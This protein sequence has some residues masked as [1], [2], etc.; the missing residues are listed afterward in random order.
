MR[1]QTIRT[2]KLFG[3]FNHVI[4]LNA[5]DRITII[6]GPNG[7][8]KTA[9]LRLISDIFESRNT[10]V[11]EL[12]FE[13]VELDFDDDSTLVVRKT[14]SGDE[15]HAKEIIYECQPHPPFLLPELLVS[16]R[17]HRDISMRNR[18]HT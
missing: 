13:T 12:P 1:L 2:E 5:D 14:D 7:Y 8:G 15:E 10:E 3:I 16:C 6:H 18:S 11:R 4:R 17:L 9:I